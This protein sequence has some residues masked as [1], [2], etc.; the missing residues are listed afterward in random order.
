[1]PLNTRSERLWGLRADRLDAGPRRGW[2]AAGT[3]LCHRLPTRTAD[4]WHSWIFHSQGASPSP[5]HGHR[6]HEGM[7]RPRAAAPGWG[8]ECGPPQAPGHPTG[9]VGRGAQP[10]G[11]E[12][13]AVRMVHCC[14]R[15]FGAMALPVSGG[16]GLPG[17]WG[18]GA[19]TTPSS[20]P[21]APSPSRCTKNQH[22]LT[23]FQPVFPHD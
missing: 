3:G 12:K 14:C 19:R 22:Q 21:R 1:M 7:A 15:L 11:E 20:A 5:S 17:P 9:S 16:V 23:W 4:A 10:E 18:A 6:G 2:V 8:P 13:A